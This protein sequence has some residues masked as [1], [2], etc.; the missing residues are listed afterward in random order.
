MGAI[1]PLL[2]QANTDTPPPNP[3][4]VTAATTES[5]EVQA[6]TPTTLDARFIE[7]AALS[8][9]HFRKNILNT[10]LVWAAQSSIYQAQWKRDS[11]LTMMWV[12]K[13]YK[14]SAPGSD[15]KQWAYDTLMNNLHM[16]R[17]VQVLP[18]VRAGIATA[19]VKSDANNEPVALAA[20]EPWGDHQFDGPATEAIWMAEF[21]VTLAQ[22]GW[23][24]DKL[25][26]TFFKDAV[27]GDNSAAMALKENLY[28]IV[29]PEFF[30]ITFDIWEEVRA[31]SHFYTLLALRKA[32]QR[33][34][35]VAQL[36]DDQPLIQKLEGPMLLEG[37]DQT[38]SAL[39]NIEL[40][41]QK[42]VD[43]SNQTYAAHYHVKNTD[44]YKEKVAIDIQ[45]VLAGLYFG[46]EDESTDYTVA[47]PRMLATMGL[48]L[49]TSR[50]L[51]PD[52]N[53]NKT[54][55]EFAPL[56]M[57]YYG[58][59][60]TGD[61]RGEYN[62]AHPW[63]LATAAAAEF[64]DRYA[65]YILRRGVATIRVEDVE[66]FRGLL[67]NHFLDGVKGAVGVEI[68][69]ENDD[70]SPSANAALFEQLVTKLAE[71]ADRFRERILSYAN[72]KIMQPGGKYEPGKYTGSFAEQMNKH[73]EGLPQGPDDLTWAHVAFLRSL[74]TRRIYGEAKEDSSEP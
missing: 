51:F 4:P 60:W 56:I 34:I 47:D 41:L 53:K 20:D 22:E 21:A 17:K 8:N 59:Y 43:H 74:E 23:T 18:G 24:K 29:S 1:A 65:H 12:L 50:D 33:G 30:A 71:R 54:E 73:V 31:E 40:R 2:V 46:S 9:K 45:S 36:L 63:V 70:G 39:E 42:H 58:D 67:P 32:I 3:E 7:Q 25:R 61:K 35:E 62:D 5:C 6:S 57:R 19:K 52:V 55:N 15:E 72:E 49:K 27:N 69:L 37:A 64:D 68:D 13:V 38:K 16:S 44:I 48:V 11:A 28:Y 10:G 66:Y 26:E 14:S